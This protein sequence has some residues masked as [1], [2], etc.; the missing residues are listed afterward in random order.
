MEAQEGAVYFKHLK[1]LVL[2]LSFHRNSRTTPPHCVALDNRALLRS[3]NP[4]FQGDSQQDVSEFQKSVCSN[5]CLE[6]L[7]KGEFK[8]VITCTSCRTLTRITEEFH[9]INLVTSDGISH[10]NTIQDLLRCYFKTEPISKSCDECNK[11]AVHFIEVSIKKCPEILVLNLVDYSNDMVKNSHN[12]NFHSDKNLSIVCNG[13]PSNLF[14]MAQCV[15]HGES[16]GS[17]HWTAEY[18]SGGACP[19]W[20][21]ANDDT[22]QKTGAPTKAGSLMFF[23]EEH[24]MLS[25]DLQAAGQQILAEKD[26]L[27]LKNSGTRRWDSVF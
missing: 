15:H 9:E 5:T 22:V 26:V 27:D 24:S 4:P 6:S 1:Q 8:K 23:I 11:T 12:V 17:G 13:K 25:A 2:S 14:L 19:S 7:F 3:L 16:I 18:R 21:K 20:Y 10:G